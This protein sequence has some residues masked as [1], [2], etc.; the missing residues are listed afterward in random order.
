[1][2]RKHHFVPQFYLSAFTD[3]ISRDNPTPYLWVVDMQKGTMKRRSVKN[4]AYNTGF[5]EWKEMGGKAPS[6]ES[7][8]SQIES[9]T[10]L[11]MKKLWSGD[12]KLT[13][14]ERYYLSIFL[15]LQ[16]TRTPRFRKAS[17]DALIKHALDWA[18]KIIGNEDALEK[19]LYKSNARKKP[20]DAPL[21]AEDIQG[22]VQNRRFKVIPNLDYTLQTTLRAGLEF[23]KLIFTMRWLFVVAV[24][25]T[26]F[27]TCDMPLALLTPDAK[28]REV[29]FDDFHNPE[30]EMAFPI[31][32]LCILLMRDHDFPE[33]IAYVADDVVNEI[34][35]RIIPVVDRYVFC[36]SERQGRWA[37]E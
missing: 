22:F 26:H 25:N 7:I 35:R 10:V 34:N 21:M 29:D 36:S 27:F 23:S 33:T 19:L 13:D 1:M 2:A 31:S 20:G 5:Y 12:F 16:L 28:P 24:E 15:G 8:Y 14:K 6:I 9:R 18:D 30:L 4:V 17:Q 37:L 32:P 3:P 11:V